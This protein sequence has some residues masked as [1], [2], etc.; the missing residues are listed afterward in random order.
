MGTEEP[1][2]CLYSI[3]WEKYGNRR[4]ASMPKL[5]R[6]REVWERRSGL[7]A[8]TQKKKRSMGT[9]ELSQSRCLYLN[10]KV[11]LDTQPNLTSKKQ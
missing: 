8:Q 10:K 4:V 3:E 9:E 1:P 11:R 6:K 7:N 5:N 2:Q